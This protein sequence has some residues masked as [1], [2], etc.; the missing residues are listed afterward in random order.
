MFVILLYICG[1]VP[2]PPSETILKTRNLDFVGN[3][4]DAFRFELTA[5]IGY[6]LWVRSGTKR[7]RDFA[8]VVRETAHIW[9]SARLLDENFVQIEPGIRGNTLI[10]EGGFSLG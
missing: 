7:R 6:V 8:L 10:E 5:R 3:W 1:S 9:Q 4:A 2:S